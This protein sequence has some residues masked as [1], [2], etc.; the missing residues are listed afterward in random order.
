MFAAIKRGNQKSEIAVYSFCKMDRFLWG[1]LNTLWQEVETD[2]L[3]WVG[4]A[5]YNLLG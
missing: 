2:E 4:V 1:F 5:K 3:N